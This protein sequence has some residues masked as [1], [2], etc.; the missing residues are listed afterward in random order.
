MT[1][2]KWQGLAQIDFRVD[3]RDNIPKLMEINPRL[4]ASVQHSINI[5]LDVPKIWVDLALSRPIPEQPLIKTGVKSRWLLPAD[6]LWFISAPKTIE[7]IKNFFN[8]RNS[9]YELLDMDDWKPILGFFIA[10]LDYLFH[11]EKRKMIIR[12]KL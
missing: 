1:H 12:Q 11:K 3:A 2:L 9:S 6:I 5:G 7:N 4:W 10:S 8:F